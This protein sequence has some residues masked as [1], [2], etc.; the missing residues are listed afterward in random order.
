[1]SNPVTK[2]Q[3]IVS[4]YLTEIRATPAPGCV[5]CSRLADEWDRDHDRDVLLEIN[6][7]PHDTPKL[8]RVEQWISAE[9]VSLGD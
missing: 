9:G 8:S 1:M 5:P 6:N 7:H 4:T 3:E 2:P